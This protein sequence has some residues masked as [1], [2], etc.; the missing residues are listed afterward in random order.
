[1]APDPVIL[2]T[3][4]SRGIGK[5]TAQLAAQAGWKVILHGRT[6]SDHLLALAKSLPP[7]YAIA[8][9][10]TD[11]ALVTSQINQAVDYFGRIDALVNCA[12]SVVYSDFLATTD[13][14]ILT[15]F[16]EHVLGTVHFCQAVIPIMQQQGYG[17]IVNISSIRGFPH[18]ATYK[19]VGYSMAKDSIRSLTASLAKIYAPQILVNAVAPGFTET[20]IAQQWSQ[21]T[22][23]KAI[24]GS[25]LKRTAQPEEIAEMILFLA[26][27]KTSF[28]TG[29]TILVDGGY[30]LGDK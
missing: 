21:E 17:R 19:S 3:G 28:I 22:R 29:Q 10:V 14:Q 18:L 13:D 16:Q 23:R 4:S 11:K 12:G 20:D 30:S 9:D 25:L 27:S 2:I 24:E 1:M 8:C 6:R 7:A 5:A 15:M 26:S